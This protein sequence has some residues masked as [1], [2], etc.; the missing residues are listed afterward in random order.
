MADTTM[1]P[2]VGDREG[3]HLAEVFPHDVQRAAADQA[4]GIILDD[5]EFLHRLVEHDQLFAEQDP[6]VD[7]R[8]DQRA[9]VRNVGGAGR[10]HGVTHVPKCIA[11]KKRQAPDRVRFRGLSFLPGVGRGGARPLRLP[12]RPRG[13]R[14]GAMS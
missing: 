3:S 13:G 8:R 14:A 7:E 9:D 5:A 12:A 6:A 11:R 4:A 2:V 1:Q 10:A